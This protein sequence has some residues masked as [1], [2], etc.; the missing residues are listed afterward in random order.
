MTSSAQLNI[1]SMGATGGATRTRTDLSAGSDAARVGGRQDEGGQSF[2]AAMQ[3]AAQRP[4]PKSTGHETK[5]SASRDDVAGRGE[6]L[7]DDP[8]A[9]KGEDGAPA[10]SEGKGKEPSGTSNQQAKQDEAGAETNGAPVTAPQAEVVPVTTASLGAGATAPATDATASGVLSDADEISGATFPTS[11]SQTAAAAGLTAQ[12]GYT[13][14]GASVADPNTGATSQGSVSGKEGGENGVHSLMSL[15]RVNGGSEA[16]TDN[17]TKIS[18]SQMLSGSEQ[19][20]AAGARGESGNAAAALSSV[21][22]ALNALA[23]A[24][25]Q[26]GSLTQPPA[27]GPTASTPLVA[28]PFGQPQWGNDVGQQ[29]QWMVSQNIQRADLKLNPA[30]LGPIEVRIVMH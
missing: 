19:A 4:Q 25:G 6:E 1:G 13:G 5:Q 2:D 30:H 28:T 14:T 20:I 3:K 10:D 27:S 11:Q 16:A 22:N 15:L 18:F 23:A 17:Q 26:A 8:V 12:K 29:V 9:A 21:S 7:P 24:P